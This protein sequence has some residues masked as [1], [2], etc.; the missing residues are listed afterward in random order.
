MVCTLP[1]EKNDVVKS[2][3]K[4]LACASLQMWRGQQGSSVDGGNLAYLQVMP[5]RSMRTSG[6]LILKC[7]YFDVSS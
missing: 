3:G 2:L 1:A 5:L 7:R 4:M 6:Y